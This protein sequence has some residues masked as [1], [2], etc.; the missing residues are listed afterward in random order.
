[1][2]CGLCIK[3]GSKVC[4]RKERERLIKKK[5]PACSEFVLDTKKV[6]GKLLRIGLDL[7]VLPTSHT[8]LLMSLLDANLKLRKQGLTLGSVACYNVEGN[9]EIVYLISSPKHHESAYGVV[10]KDKPRKNTTINVTL[11]KKYF[12]EE[13]DRKL[14]E[15]WQNLESG[16]VFLTDDRKRQKLLYKI[17]KKMPRNY[18]QR[19]FDINNIKIQIKGKKVK[20]VSELLFKQYL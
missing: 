14:K 1:M 5:T 13:R 7:S 3:K 18:V 19:M 4:H 9:T 2:F 15:I 10:F 17:L 20:E 11:D 12:I 8:M 16:F 6:S